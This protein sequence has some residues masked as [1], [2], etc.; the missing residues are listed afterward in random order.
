[1]TRKMARVGTALAAI[2]IAAGWMA[3]AGAQGL[4][5]GV[6]PGSPDPSAAPAGAYALDPKH[7]AVIARVSHIGYSYSVFRFDKVKGDLAWDPAAPAKSTVSITVQTASIATNVTGFAEELSG[8]RFLNSQAFP[9]ASFVSTAFH[10]TDALHGKVDGQF[11]LL[12]KTAPLTFDVTLVGAGKGFMGHPRMGVH[13]EAQID[14]K[15]YGLPGMFQV[16]IALV[17]DTE[18]IKAS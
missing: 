4:P 3:S 12:G 1:M 9:E 2:T 5:P 16:P 17:V 18:F 15:T 13:A 10:R 7:A 14:P 6:F 11:T 8:A